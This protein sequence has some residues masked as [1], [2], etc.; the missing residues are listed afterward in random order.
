MQTALCYGDPVNY[1]IPTDYRCAPTTSYGI[2]KLAGESYMML[3]NIPVISLRLANICAP[4]LAIGP[5]PTFYKRLRAKQDCYC[6]DSKRDF[7]DIDDFL[8]LIDIILKDDETTG[9]FNVSSGKGTKIKDIFNYIASYLNIADTD[10][11]V[12]PVADDDIAYVVLDPSKTKSVFGWQANVSVEEM[13]KK[14]LQW[15][16]VNGIDTIYSHLKP[17]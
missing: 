16:E 15:Y 12:V 17:K 1:P 10:I 5:I 4:R 9:I 7:L 14:Q 8:D 2:S 11:E 13:I 6:T 3:A